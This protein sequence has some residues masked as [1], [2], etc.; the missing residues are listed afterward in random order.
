[1]I[2]R[3]WSF[4]RIKCNLTQTTHV[5]RF[6]LMTFLAMIPFSQL[7]LHAVL[8][9]WLMIRISIYSKEIIRF[10]LFIQ[11]IH[12][13]VSQRMTVILPVQLNQFKKQLVFVAVY[14]RILIFQI[15]SINMH[16]FER[17][18]IRM[19]AHDELKKSP[20]R[21]PNSSVSHDTKYLISNKTAVKSTEEKK[22]RLL[23]CNEYIKRLNCSCAN[24]YPPQL[25]TSQH[26]I[27]DPFFVDCK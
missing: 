20:K 26:N 23:V 25:L 15:H 9:L 27:H 11:S 22:K 19:Q 2:E 8:S 21:K 12:F 5:R 16:A 13:S 17:S 14:C 7:D 1:M 18:M 4:Y 6:G 3:F 10:K 24:V